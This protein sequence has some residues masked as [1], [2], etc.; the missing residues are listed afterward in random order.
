MGREMRGG[1]FVSKI[2]SLRRG[3]KGDAQQDIYD[4][5]LPVIEKH[6]C[7]NPGTPKN[8]QFWGMVD[9]SIGD[10]RMYLAM[11]KK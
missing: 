4:A 10:I 11:E 1:D 3:K 8:D 9:S 6:I 2:I 7:G 5:L